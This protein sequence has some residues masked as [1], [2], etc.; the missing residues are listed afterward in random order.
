MICLSGM[1]IQA[2]ERRQSSLLTAKL[3]CYEHFREG[4]TQ[5]GI[6]KQLIS[7]TARRIL[8]ACNKLLS[9]KMEKQ[10]AKQQTKYMI[11]SEFQRSQS[12]QQRKI[13]YAKLRDLV[14]KTWDLKKCDRDAW[15]PLKMLA[16]HGL[17]GAYRDSLWVPLTVR[18][19]Y[20]DHYFTRQQMS[21]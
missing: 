11:E 2:F 12:T 4:E 16:F 7:R 18:I 9:P 14:E 17:F 5:R 21:H 1:M 19:C 10:T 3:Y 20:R 6:N 13:S 15:M 8:I